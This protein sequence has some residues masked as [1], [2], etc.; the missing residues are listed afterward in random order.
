M[1]NLDNLSKCIYL[2]F[3]S[4]YRSIAKLFQSW[5]LRLSFIQSTFL[6]PARSTR[7]APSSKPNRVFTVAQISL[8]LTLSC[9]VLN[10]REA[11]F[12]PFS[13]VHAWKQL[14]FSKCL[15]VSTWA[16]W[17]T[18]KGVLTVNTCLLS[19][20]Q[21]LCLEKD[22]GPL[23]QTGTKWLPR[24]DTLLPFKGEFVTEIP[25]KTNMNMPKEYTKAQLVMLCS[26]NINQ[27][28]M[29]LSK[30]DKQDL[31]C[32]LARWQNRAIPF[33]VCVLWNAAWIEPGLWIICHAPNT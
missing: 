33:C 7:V 13:G 10:V 22:S 1:R 31:F 5:K 30:S 18:L 6:V 26:S 25:M 23:C 16:L 20:L 2:F 4:V 19:G 32:F 17:Q 9:C 24:W 21:V 28:L 27:T 14:K 15:T 29:F 3:I 12:P 11:N 8:M